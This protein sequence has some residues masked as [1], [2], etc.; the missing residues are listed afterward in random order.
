MRRLDDIRT[1][2]DARSAIWRC[3]NSSRGYVAREIYEQH[4]ST[5]PKLAYAA[6]MTAWEHDHGPTVEAFET[7]DDFAAALREVAPPIKRKRPLRVW[8]GIYVRDA[9]PMEAAVGLSWTRDRDIACWF[10]MRF[11]EVSGVRPF[12]FETY[13]PP[14]EIVTFYDGRGEAEVIVDTVPL[15]DSWIMVDGT[16]ISHDELG[17]DSSAPAER[18]AD[19]RTA[20]AT[21]SQIRG[22]NENKCR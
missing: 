4:R 14:E 12:V 19:W 22:R 21:Q 6:L 1:I 11:S 5:N 15:Y 7:E 8:R 10:A 2:A 16:R 13:V 18:L 17:S 9:H 20:W 3:S